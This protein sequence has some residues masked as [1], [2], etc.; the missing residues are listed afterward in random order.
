MLDASESPDRRKGERRG[1]KPQY[2]TRADV[3]VRVRL[4]EEQRQ[5]LEQVARDNGT[6]LSGAIREAINE[7]AADYRENNPVFQPKRG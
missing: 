5:D 4:T 3:V 2:D 7:F 6:T 1:P